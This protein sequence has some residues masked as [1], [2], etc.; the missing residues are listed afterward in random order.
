MKCICC[1]A[2]VRPLD[3]YDKEIKNEEDAV[4][5]TIKH[6][7]STTDDGEEKATYTRAEN[8]MWGDGIV[9]NIS[10]G[11]GSKRDGDCYVIAICDECIE[12][13]K[14][15]GTVAHIGDYMMPDYYKEN[16]EEESRKIWRRYNQLDDLLE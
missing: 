7:G 13:K 16:E 6:R 2:K 3:S 15:N 4:F 12:A 5:K 10:A 9:G 8:R 14:L 1:D 11:Y